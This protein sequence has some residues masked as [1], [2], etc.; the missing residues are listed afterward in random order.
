MFE[1]AIHGFDDDV[2]EDVVVRSEPLLAGLAARDHPNNDFFHVKTK[3]PHVVMM[4]FLRTP[5]WADDYLLPRLG[6][7]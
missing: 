7:S 3:N 1:R 6:M 4:Q 5:R 2:H